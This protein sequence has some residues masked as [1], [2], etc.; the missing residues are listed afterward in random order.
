[1]SAINYEE[2]VPEGVA[3]WRARR[4]HRKFEVITATDLL[5]GVYEPDVLSQRVE[6]MLPP[7]ETSLDRMEAIAI[8]LAEPTQQV[9]IIDA[10]LTDEEQLAVVAERSYRFTNIHEEG[11]EKESFDKL[12]LA[13]SN[14]GRVQVKRN[15]WRPEQKGR[16]MNTKHDHGSKDITLLDVGGNFSD[17][18][19]EENDNGE[20]VI[21]YS[22]QYNRQCVGEEKDIPV[23]EVRL[24]RTAQRVHT[25][26]SINRMSEILIHSPTMQ[27]DVLTSTLVLTVKGA[28]SALVY[29]REGES[30]P[31][32]N[33]PVDVISDL[34][35]LRSVIRK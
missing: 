7:G 11:Q 1:M 2:I 31:V 3:T 33:V 22:S 13:A 6:Q 35:R 18:I 28:Q 20:P 34:Q 4:P 5:F 26:G 9:G 15:I 32:G 17:D 14:D 25:P 24:K 19:F 23:K 10:I 21:A 30:S 16:I 27:P 8:V 29:K 12:V